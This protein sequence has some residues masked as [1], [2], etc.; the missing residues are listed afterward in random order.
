MAFEAKEHPDVTVVRRISR[1]YPFDVLGVQTQGMIG[2]WMVQ[3]LR[4][5]VP[6]R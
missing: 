5:A 3:A 6:G 2:Y 4:N 1:P